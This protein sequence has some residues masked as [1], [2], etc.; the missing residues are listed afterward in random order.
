M[1]LTKEKETE[2]IMQLAEDVAPFV[3]EVESGIKTTRNNYGRYGAMLTRLSKG[4][5]KMAM[6][7]GYAMMQAGANGQGVHD[8][9][10]AF[11]P[12]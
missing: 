6:I 7:L 1:K 5:K 8:A 9:L 4:N 12:E 11:F 10:Q 2:L 3:R